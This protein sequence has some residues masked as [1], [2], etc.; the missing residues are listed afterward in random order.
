MTACGTSTAEAVTT[1][2]AGVISRYSGAS[3]PAVEIAD[4]FEAVGN[5]IFFPE[6]VVVDV[7][8][9]PWG[10]VEVFELS[11]AACDWPQRV[12]RSSVGGSRDAQATSEWWNDAELLGEDCPEFQAALRQTATLTTGVFYKPKDRN[13]TQDGQWQSHDKTWAQWIE[14]DKA[15][16]WGLSWHFEDPR[17]VGSVFVYASTVEKA[18]TA[19]S[20]C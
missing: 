13:N 15:A 12:K 10:E 16:R 19:K 3:V 4:A 8:L 17:K 14:G 9:S 6:A 1:N 11:D 2:A 7:L 18:R 5:V 20:V